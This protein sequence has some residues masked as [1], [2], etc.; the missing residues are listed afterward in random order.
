MT[1]EFVTKEELKRILSGKSAN[2]WFNPVDAKIY[3]GEKLE[4][5]NGRTRTVPTYEEAVFD[6]NKFKIAQAKAKAGTLDASEADFMPWIGRWQDVH[7]ERIS[8]QAD[9]GVMTNALFATQDTTTVLNRLMGTEIRGFSIPDA[10]TTIPTD[11]LEYN[12]DVYTRFNISTDVPEG[13]V[14]WTKNGS[15]ATTSFDLTKDVGH[16]S[17]TDEQVMKNRQNVWG[18]S[19]NNV[20]TDFRRA[21]SAKIADVLETASETNSA[22]WDA[23]SSGLSSNNPLADIFPRQD[24]ILANNGDA[25]VFVSANTGYS[26]FTGNTFINGPYTGFGGMQA[27]IQSNARVVTNF[28]QLPGVSWYIDNE[29]LSTSVIIMSKDAVVNVQGPTRV[30]QYRTEDAGV[31][32]YVARDWYQCKIVQPGR[33]A[34]LTTVTA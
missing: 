17:T 24:A 18:A 8:A 4:T 27:G 30:G 5:E 20:A 11:T 29:L 33:I 3:T 13:V 25:T 34:E 12:I 22:D 2:A 23:F 32:G 26:A 14:A 1:T 7:N 6:T 9:A 16:I 10:V 19:I 28:P 15:V 31:D 21:K